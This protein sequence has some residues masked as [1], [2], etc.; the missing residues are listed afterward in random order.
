MAEGNSA[1]VAD[2]GAN[3]VCMLLILMTVAAARPHAKDAFEAP[4][5]LQRAMPL[6]GPAQNDLLY[7]RLRPDHPCWR[8][9]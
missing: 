3:L 9:N 5:P 4:I 7:L 1:I 2:L 6:S 8:W